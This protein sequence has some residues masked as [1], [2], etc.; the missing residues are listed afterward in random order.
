MIYARPGQSP[1]AWRR[2]LHQV[3][4]LC[5]DHLSLYQLTIEQGTPFFDLQRRGKLKVPDPDLA[6]DLYEMTL[7]MTAAADL[8][9]YEISN[10][11]R[12]GSECSH[13]LV[14]WR[15]HDYA[16]IGPGAHGRLTLDGGKWA[17]ATHREPEIWWQAAMASGHGM[18]EFTRLLAEE[19]ADEF[20]LMG[21]R[22]REGLDLARYERNA[23]RPL[24]P[25]RLDFLQEKGFVE[26]LA[27]GRIR[28]TLKGFLV[29]D[30]IVADL[31]A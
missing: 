6:A 8:P 13:N 4:D 14:Y 9:A 24:V 18:E 31:A 27:D 7:A 23:G 12:P 15:Y 21:L 5:A 3:L 2:E 22:L 16:G 26:R 25:D 29:L 11:A 19:E 1:V 10:H 30:A 28:A 20:L 17:S